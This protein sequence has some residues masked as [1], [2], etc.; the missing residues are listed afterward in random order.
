MTKL[1]AEH[2]NDVPGQ[3]EEQPTQ[4]EVYWIAG[5]N[6]GY[7]FVTSTQNED[8]DSNTHAIH[9][10]TG[11]SD[12]QKEETPFFQVP[13][14][15]K[16]HLSYFSTYIDKVE[17]GVAQALSNSR[18]VQIIWPQNTSSDQRDFGIGILLVALCRSAYHSSA[19]HYLPFTKG[20]FLW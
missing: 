8:V 17:K 9:V 11:S 6:I 12:A 14:A 5:T 7:C 2:G 20:N 18:S 13:Q 15:P 16:K 19:S 3:K 10:G 1:A 4:A